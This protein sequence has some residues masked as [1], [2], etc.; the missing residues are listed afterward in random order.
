M[1]NNCYI[2]VE[3]VCW[4]YAGSVVVDSDSVSCFEFRVVVF[5]NFLEMSMT[6]L[7]TIILILTS[8]NIGG[9]DSFG[10]K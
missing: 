8:E 10:E 5:V 2:Y 1:L 3:G 9:D 7:T 4:S 6:P